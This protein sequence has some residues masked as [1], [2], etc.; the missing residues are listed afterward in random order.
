MNCP[1][2]PPL[3]FIYDRNATFNHR[4]LDM[5]VDGCRNYA[6]RQ[7]WDIAGTWTDHGDDALSNGHRPA[8]QS[9]LRRMLEVSRSRTV[10]CLVHN[11]DRYAHDRP[12]RV[13][14][15]QRVALA[16]GY[17]ATTFNETDLGGVVA[18][19]GKQQSR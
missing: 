8:F 17:T 4:L 5:R 1:P 14:F 15:Q 10:L 12:S 11:W 19:V 2:P 3:A 9:L 16:G 18:L 13:D 7:R 6:E